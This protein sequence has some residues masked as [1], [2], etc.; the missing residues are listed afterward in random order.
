[1]IVEQYD[2]EFDM[3]SRF[4]LEVIKDEAAMTEKFV[5]GLR[6]YLQGFVRAFRPTSHADALCLALNMSLHERANPSKVVGRGSTLGKTFRELPACRSC[7]RYHGGR[8]LAGI[9]TPTSQQ[10]RVF[11]T[12]RQE[13]EQ[14][15]T[16]VIGIDWLSANHASIDCSRKE[17]VFNPPST[18]SFKFKGARTVVLSKVI[19]AMKAKNTP[20]FSSNELQEFPP[21]RKIN[22]AIE[23]ELGTASISRAPYR[24]AP[25]ELKELKVQ[26]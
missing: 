4:A 16:V 19:P 21:P 6:L 17:V 9:G 23:L 24:I 8:C 25:A 1:M 18:T 7:G 13:A 5:R 26:L 20:T 22:F 12:N 2:V 10:G 14:A 11:A 3:L 15:G